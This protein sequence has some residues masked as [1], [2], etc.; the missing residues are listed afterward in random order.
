MTQSCGVRAMI[1]STSISS[2]IDAAIVDLAARHDLQVADLRLGVGAAVRF[3]EADDD[4]D[5][6]APEARARPRSSSS[7]LPTPGAAPM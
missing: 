6:F 2:R 5:A 1:A 4:V 3:D 7:V